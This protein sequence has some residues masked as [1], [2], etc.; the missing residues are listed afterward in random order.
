MWG[1]HEF[2][3][4]LWIPLMERAGLLERVKDNKGVSRPVPA[5]GPHV[6]R[7]VAASLWI[8]QDLTPKRVQHLLGHSSIRMTMDLYGHLWEDRAGDAA[9]ASASERLIFG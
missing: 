3:Q 4:D 9:L 5:F 1:Y 8:A 6:L 7:H 2:R